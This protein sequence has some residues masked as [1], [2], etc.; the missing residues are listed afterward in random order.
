MA[1]T[2]PTAGE[3]IKIDKEYV[4]IIKSNVE[5]DKKYL[6]DTGLPSKIIYFCRDC[7][8]MTKP[9]RVGKK[10]QFSCTECK[11]KNVSFGSE[12]SIDNYYKLKKHKN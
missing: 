1:S 3:P 12:K 4:D 7:K 2:D 9:K 6:E 5:I 10:F 11:G 8:K